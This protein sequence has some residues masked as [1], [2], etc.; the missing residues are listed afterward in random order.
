MPPGFFFLYNYPGEMNIKAHI[1]IRVFTCY[2]P[3]GYLYFANF[4]LLF[5]FLNS[6]KYLFY[7]SFVFKRL[8]KLGINSMFEIC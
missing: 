6:N 8:C 4:N 7:N 5:F 3:Y 2:S 1:H